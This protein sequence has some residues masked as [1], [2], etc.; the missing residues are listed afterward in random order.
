MTFRFQPRNP[1][2][3]LWVKLKPGAVSRTLAGIT[4]AYKK[5]DPANPLTYGFV[6]QD[7]DAQYQAEQRT[8][9]II[10]YFSVLTILIS[11]LGLFGLAAFTL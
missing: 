8:G 4:K 2:F 6:D 1:F 5:A 3:T 11:C 7:L 10:L 9:R